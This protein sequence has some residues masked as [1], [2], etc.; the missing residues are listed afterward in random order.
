MKALRIFSLIVFVLMTAVSIDLLI[1]FLGNL[2]P[3]LNDGLGIH[4]IFLPGKLFFGDSLWSLERFYNA[5][6]VSILIT[7]ALLCE[8]I[9][10]TIV[11]IIKTNNRHFYDNSACCTEI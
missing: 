11:C 4:T 2:V 8:N 5:I 7:F 6:T 10:L 9:V 3:D 1:H